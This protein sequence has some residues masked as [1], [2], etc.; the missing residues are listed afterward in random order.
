MWK[1]LK[2]GQK[3][4][5]I[6]LFISLLPLAAI[7]FYTLSFARAALIKKTT[8]ALQAVTDSRASHISHSIR[9]RQEQA[10]EFAGSYL[11]R[12]MSETGV[13]DPE[14]IRGIQN[15]I[16]ATFL[17]LNITPTSHY[18]N[19]DRATD[20]AIIGVWD[21][22][23]TIIA[24]TDRSLIGMR[25]PPGYMQKVYEQG[26]YFRGFVTD[27]LTKKN[28]LIH[29]EEIRNWKTNR[30][31]GALSLKVRAK[32]LDEITTSRE[33][34]GV[35]GETY[36]VDRHGA[37]ITQSRFIKDS[38]LKVRV[39]TPGTRACFSG[40]KA[41]MIYKNYRG[42]EVL[43]VQKYLPDE[44]WCLLSE[45]DAEEALEPVRELRGK[46]MTIGWALIAVILLLST[47]IARAFT[48]PIRE[49]SAAAQEVAQ[50]RY[51][52]KV[53]VKTRDEIG[54]LAE[55]FNNMVRSLAKAAEQLEEKSKTL[56]KHL[57]LTTR[58]RKELKEVNQ[59]LDSFVYT[60][61][62]DLRAPL[63][64]IASFASFLEEDYADKLDDKG[65]DYIAEIK[66]GAGKMN[67]FIEDLLQ[68]SRI[69]RIKNPYEPVAMGQLVTDV[70]DRLKFDIESGKVAMTVQKDMPTVMCDRIKLTEVFYNLINNA[71]KFS[72]KDNTDNPKIVVGC[73]EEGPDYRFFVK[74]NGI[75]IDPKYHDQIFG[76]FKRL[77][78]DK[79]YEGTGA[80]LSIIKRVIDD[81]QGRI[82]IDSVLGQGATFNFTIPKDLRNQDEEGESD[83]GTEAS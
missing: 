17:D 77:H 78:T 39:D 40:R 73:V 4:V 21:V 67:D 32:I 11:L 14:I 42:V 31:V 64:G 20:V 58:Q 26:T 43:G 8:D 35:S 34:L 47:L 12:Q 19:I 15:D 7:S 69:S 75:G 24:N 25:M 50:G 53:E 70:L 29:L 37:M 82:W 38:I 76:I 65:R 72:S 28:F 30:I 55:A 22:H 18:E 23:G 46:T 60:A 79:E 52:T 59:E 63:R 68:L 83:K 41:P 81:H 6:L 5:I 62:H 56:F 66:K 74:D 49:L 45:I 10:K 80:G 9:L 2:I 36:V 44:Q 3:L 1:Y 33:G 51:D 71:I 48:R 13:N 54:G 27:P 16:D 61:S 57:A